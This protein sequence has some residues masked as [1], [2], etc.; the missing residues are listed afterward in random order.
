MGWNEA[1]GVTIVP[2]WHMLMILDALMCNGGQRPCSLFFG[3]RS[4]GENSNLSFES[5]VEPADG[6]RG[7]ANVNMDPPKYSAENREVLGKNSYPNSY[8]SS[9]PFS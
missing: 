8:P 1:A 9:Y 4:V 6:Q 7:S 5:R 2:R 3:H